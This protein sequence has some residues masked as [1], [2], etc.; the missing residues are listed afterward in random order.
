M[1]ADLPFATTEHGVN[2]VV[3]ES[4]RPD[5][6]AIGNV[7]LLYAAASLARELRRPHG[8]LLGT[9]I[10]FEP[11]GSGLRV[12]A[13]GLRNVYGLAFDDSGRLYG[14]DNDGFTQA[15]LAPRGG[16]RDQPRAELRVPV[17]RDVR[18]PLRSAGPPLWVLDT[19]GSG[20]LA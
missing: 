6:V 3:L 4:R 2:D 9:V 18:P 20:G 15:E 19:A 10:S 11:D 8:N 7:D 16:A 1:L 5:L 12:Y 14:V 13:K 17:G